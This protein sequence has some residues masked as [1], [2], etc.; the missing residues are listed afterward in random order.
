M[1][2]QKFE[3]PVRALIREPHMSLT[4]PPEVSWI[5]VSKLIVPLK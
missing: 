5:E 3:A 4:Y 1:P 2:S